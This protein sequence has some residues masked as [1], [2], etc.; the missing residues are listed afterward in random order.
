VLTGARFPVASAPLL[1]PVQPLVVLGMAH[2]GA[3]GDR[4]LPRQAFLKS[5]RTV[6]GPGEPIVIDEDL[7]QV[8]N[9]EGELA[10]VIRR[11]CRHLAAEQV[12]DAILGYTV[13]NDVTAVDQVPLDEKMTQSKHWIETVLDAACVPIDVTVD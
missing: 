6:I 9:I 4:D 7:G 8:V 5:P 10:V 11:F 2:N 12:P 13:G 1:A 3:P